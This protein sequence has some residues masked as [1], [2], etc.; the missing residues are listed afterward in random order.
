MLEAAL[1]WEDLPRFATISDLP[2]SQAATQAAPSPQLLSLHSL[3]TLQ[4]IAWMPEETEWRY[5]AAQL[6]VLEPCG[7]YTLECRSVRPQVET[8]ISPYEFLGV[9]IAELLALLV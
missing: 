9:T 6:A 8:L 1:G 7:R 5:C 2:T 3:S 4:S